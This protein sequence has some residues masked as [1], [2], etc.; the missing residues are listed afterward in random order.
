MVSKRAC[1]VSLIWQVVAMAQRLTPRRQLEMPLQLGRLAL[2]RSQVACFEAVRQGIHSKSQIAIAARLDLTKTLRTLD[3]LAKLRLVK[4]TA[5]QQWR[6]TERGR[7]CL[8]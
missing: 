6:T 5:D 8:F 1:L 2:T 7:N 4:K 3:A